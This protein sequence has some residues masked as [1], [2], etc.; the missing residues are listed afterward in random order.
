MAA[1]TLQVENHDATLGERPVAAAEA[2]E[3]RGMM[4]SFHGWHDAQHTIA[5]ERARRLHD[6][7]ARSRAR[8]EAGSRR[9]WPWIVALAAVMAVGFEFVGGDNAPVTTATTPVNELSWRTVSAPSGA[10]RVSLPAKPQSQAVDSAA[11]WGEQLEARVPQMTIAVT[12]FAV[13]GAPARALV[14]PMMQERA[15]ALD[16]YVDNIRPVGSRT[17]E[18]FE[19]VVHT[20][21]S[22]AV[23]RVVLAGS[24]LYIIE[25]RGDVDSPR[26]KLIYDRVVLSF[27]P[28]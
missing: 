19:G 17:G 11:G 1:M 24:T 15:N 27:A 5:T 10:F 8:R 26:A 14:E 9:R 28:H 21:T 6:L 16:G 13:T 23:V 22:V 2:E 12:A 25:L 3:I 20:T 4:P 18:S 7:R